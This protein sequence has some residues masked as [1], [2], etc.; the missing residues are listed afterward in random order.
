MRDPPSQRDAGAPRPRIVRFTKN[1]PTSPRRRRADLTVSKEAAPEIE[2]A[3]DERRSQLT[4]L[5]KSLAHAAGLHTVSPIHIEAA[6]AVLRAKPPARPWPAAIGALFAGASLSSLLPP[7][8]RGDA[9]RPFEGL[10]LLIVLMAGGILIM[11]EGKPAGRRPIRLWSSLRMLRFVARLI[12]SRHPALSS[13]RQPLLDPQRLPCQQIGDAG[14]GGAV[15][16][17]G[18]GGVGAVG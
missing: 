13:I 1:V 16:V 5:A 11:L 15:A 14:T 8:T 3:V 2:K 6:R 12:R 10:A 17:E 18:V 9:L 7:L 4:E